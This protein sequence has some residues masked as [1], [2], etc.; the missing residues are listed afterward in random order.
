MVTLNRPE[1][2]NALD[3]ET[4]RSVGRAFARCEADPHVRVVI[5]T[6]AR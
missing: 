4:T 5:L 2:A 3:L 1:R 6:G